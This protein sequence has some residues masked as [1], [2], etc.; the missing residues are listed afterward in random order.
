MI[1]KV[2]VRLSKFS[3]EFKIWISLAQATF[4]FSVSV[5]ISI[6]RDSCGKFECS[7]WFFLGWNFAIWTVSMTMLVNCE[8]VLI[9]LFV[10]AIWKT[11][12]LP[13]LLESDLGILSL[14]HFYADLDV[15]SPRVNIPHY[16]PCARLVIKEIQ[17]HTFTL[18][19]GKDGS[20]AGAAD[21]LD[22]FM[23][24]L[25]TSMDKTT[26]NQIRR[27]VFELKKVLDIN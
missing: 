2:T 17:C 26:R 3:E 9:F 7:D 25:G 13:G 4:G 5:I 18:C 21:S 24:S 19:S 10:S 6:E 1:L 14:D 20:S 27:K 11:I 23:S 15:L 12:Y 8:S 22:D 16:G